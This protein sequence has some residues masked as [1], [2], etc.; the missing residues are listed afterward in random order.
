MIDILSRWVELDVHDIGVEHHFDF[1]TPLQFRPIQ[2][3]EY[4]SVCSKRKIL[5]SN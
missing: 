4:A 5:V 3:L 1:F 2:L